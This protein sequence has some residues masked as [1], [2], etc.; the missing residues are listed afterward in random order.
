VAS[1]HPLSSTWL[2][3]A[4]GTAALAVGACIGALLLGA[5]VQ[6]P[7][8]GPPW[9]WLG[10]VLGLSFVATASW[11]VPR[12]GV[13]VFSLVTV[14]G[15]L[16]AALVLDVVAP[17]DGAGLQAQVV[18]GVLLTYVAVLVGAGRIRIHGVGRRTGS[19]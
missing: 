1:R 13:L 16:T 17:V 15:Q 7:S 11:A 10:G 9:M 12:Y 18:A 2:N 5:R 6:V 3:F 19:T 4:F 14:A 8:P